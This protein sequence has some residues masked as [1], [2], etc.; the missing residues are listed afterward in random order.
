MLKKIIFIAA[1]IATLIP[2]CAVAQDDS[3]SDNDDLQVIEVEL[4]KATSKKNSEAA[5]V[6]KS[7]ELKDTS[8]GGLSELSPFTEV[9]VIQKRYMP[10]T[11]R[12]QFFGG[13]NLV[14]NNPFFETFGVDFKGS[15]FLNETWGLEATYLNL[16]TNEA[17]S[18]QELKA[19]QNVT[20]ENLIYP[21]S[22]IG[23][24]LTWF[25]MYGKF[26]LFNKKIIPFDMYF[27]V[28]YGSTSTQSN[29]K[30][31]TLHFGTGQIF[32]ITKGMAARWDFSWHNFSA[33]GIDN[34]TGVFNFLFLSV[35]ASFFFPEATYR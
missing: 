13:L 7:S 32:S 28:G 16:N 11:G 25:P 23:L 12:F 24:D 9:S 33:K 1:V 34:T 27:S 18:T 22:Y 2:I 8:F 26:S 20:T 3:T 6:T 30:P 10:K 4:E 21:K 29:E 15:Y 19:F 5:T 31:G 14:T 17:K 35:G